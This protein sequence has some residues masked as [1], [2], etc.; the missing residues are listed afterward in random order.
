MDEQPDFR[1]CEKWLSSL[2]ETLGECWDDLE[3]RRFQQLT[4]KGNLLPRTNHALV[5]GQSRPRPRFCLKG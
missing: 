3:Y 4:A 2:C 5:Q 1:L